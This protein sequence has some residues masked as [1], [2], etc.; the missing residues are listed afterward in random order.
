MPQPPAWNQLFTIFPLTEAEVKRIS[1][2]PDAPHYHE[3]EELI[4]GIEGQIEHFIDFKLSMLQAP[5]VSFVTK[6]KIHRVVP[7]ELNGSCQMWVLRFQSEFIAETTFQL[8]AHYHDRANI[9]LQN[10]PFFQRL[11]SLCTLIYGEM[12]ESSP[13]LAVVRHLL[14]GLLAMVEV[15]R[16]KTEQHPTEQFSRQNTS[17]KNF[18]ALLEENYQRPVGVE[19]YADQLFMSPRNLNL[20]CKQILQKSVSELI[21]ARKLVQAKNLLAST[22]KTI[23]E[24]GYELGYQEKAYFTAVFKKKVGITPT[25]FR[26]EMQKMTSL[27]PNFQ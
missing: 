5:F 13:D 3:Y 19:F 10:G 24:I 12:Q 17:F 26:S 18:L 15:E 1:A 16:Q 20:I 27:L 25:S 8:Y 14:N 4:I 21:E 7:K 9:S 6:G 23:A 22:D 2:A 11:V